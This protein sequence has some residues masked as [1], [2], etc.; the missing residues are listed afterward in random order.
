ME[1]HT[2]NN[3]VAGSIV[4]VGSLLVAFGV[5]QPWI[6]V[7]TGL[8]QRLGL[9]PGAPVG[10]DVPNADGRDTDLRPYLLGG[11]VLFVVC[12]VA[13]I[14]TRVR[15]LGVVWR[16]LVLVGVVFLG[17]LAGEMWNFIG[18]PRVSFTAVQDIGAASLRPGLGLWLLTA[19]LVLAVVG[20][21]VPA[22]K[23]TV[24]ASGTGYPPMPPAGWYVDPVR[25]ALLRWFD[26][27]A[28]THDT[29][30]RIG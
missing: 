6:S 28:W 23:G 26:G 13:L 15:G 3:V 7:G 11:A 4:L 5:T 19:G 25:P 1:R 9:R 18:N 29:R 8:L 24:P 16:L 22:T 12:A 21:L 30:P 27:R 20:A 10:F 17:L 14:A 2:R